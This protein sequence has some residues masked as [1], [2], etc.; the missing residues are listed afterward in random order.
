MKNKIRLLGIIAMVAIIGFTMAACALLSD[1]LGQTAASDTNNATRILGT[2]TDEEGRAWEF[3]SD[4]KLLYESNT[5]SYGTFDYTLVGTTLT[6]NL[7]GSLWQRYNVS[8]STNGNTL[9]LSGGSRV[10]GWSVA[11]P[12]MAKNTLTRRK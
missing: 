10:F 12:G 8:I 11:G 4:E 9:S 5:S 3:G 6:L 2:W 7:N 1:V